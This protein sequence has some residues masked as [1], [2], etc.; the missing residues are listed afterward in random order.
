VE[1]LFDQFRIGDGAVCCWGTQF[2]AE[3]VLLLSKFP[4]VLIAF[5]GD[6]PGKE[7]AQKLGNELAVFTDVSILNLPDGSDPDSLSSKELKELRSF[8]K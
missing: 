6:K 8:L 7:A 1:G 4:R 5:D 3:Q 2:T